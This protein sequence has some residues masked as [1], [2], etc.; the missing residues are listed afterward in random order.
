MAWSFTSN[1]S[2]VSAILDSHG[3]EQC[4]QVSDK[5]ESSVV[6]GPCVG[7]KRESWKVDG[8][9]IK[10]VLGGCIDNNPTTPLNPQYGRL[11]VTPC[12]VSQCGGKDHQWSLEPKTKQLVSA[13]G[14]MGEAICAEVQGYGNH[15]AALNGVGCKTAAQGVPRS[16]QFTITPEKNRV[17]VDVRFDQASTNRDVGMVGAHLARASF[18]VAAN[19]SVVAASLC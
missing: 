3:G 9:Q 11:V 12:D 5:D 17:S 2:I 6:V 4:L 16:Q 14:G 8:R 15:W 19:W 18:L 10:S 7:A 1:G 13:V